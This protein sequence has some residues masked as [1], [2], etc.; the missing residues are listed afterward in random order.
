M[1]VSEEIVISKNARDLFVDRNNRALLIYSQHSKEKF[2]IMYKLAKD[3]LE[4]NAKE[5]DEAFKSF[6]AREIL[7]LNEMLGNVINI[8]R[9]EWVGDV[10]PY[11]IIENEKERKTC[12]LCK[13]KNNK[14]VFHIKNKFNGK[15]VNV[16]STCIG[17]FDSLEYPS[18]VSKKEVIKKARQQ[19]RLQDLIFKF[20]G[21]EKIVTSWEKELDIYEVLIPQEIE[22]PYREVGKK[23]KQQYDKH[24]K[25]GSSESDIKNIRKYLLDRKKFI[26]KMKKYEEENKNQDFVVTMEMV[27]WLRRKKDLETIE[28][29]KRTGY[30]QS[31]LAYK[32]LEPKFVES[33][34]PKFNQH[35]KKNNI[36]IVNYNKEELYFKIKPFYHLEFHLKVMC[37]KLIR[38]FGSLIFDDK[39]Y[40][41][42]SVNNIFSVAYLF[43][44]VEQEIVINEL[45]RIQSSITMKLHHFGYE[46]DHF[47]RNEI[48]L[49]DT[50]I[51]KY[52][53]VKMNKFLEDFKG[54]AFGLADV[55]EIE[56]YVDYNLKENVR[57]FT[58]EELWAIRDTSDDETLED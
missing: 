21:I 56:K 22:E 27:K 7:L 20:P 51:K 47:E 30:V 50:R 41:K 14:L 29:L 10:D 37:N 18:G 24:L 58:Y 36:E 34:I 52:I 57:T 26:I 35:F 48:D 17:A 3:Y 4:S 8:C 54:V 45:N 13:Q 28:V 53:V 40:I 32:I 25:K 1:T 9:N 19:S 2:P 31:R 42:P 38:D 15:R 12:S 5:I 39:S 33:L 23:L 44:E 43:S 16:G 55:K 49:F 46:Y 11:A 6:D